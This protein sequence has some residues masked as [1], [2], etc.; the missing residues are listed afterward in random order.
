M[1]LD[2]LGISVVLLSLIIY[3]KQGGDYVGKYQKYF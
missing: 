3:V 2:I 1:S